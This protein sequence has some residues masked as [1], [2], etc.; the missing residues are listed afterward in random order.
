MPL[1]DV[2]RHFSGKLLLLLLAGAAA[3]VLVYRYGLSADGPR[4]TKVGTV[5]VETVATGLS[6]PW[7]LAFLP[8]GRMLVTE[9]TGTLRL[10][11]KDGKLSAPLSGVPEV[12][13]RGQ[14]GLLDVAIDPDFKSNNV[15]YLTYSEPGEGGVGTAVARGKL[16]ESG[17]ENVEVI[18]RQMP[19]V[20]GGN[21]F[22]SRLVFAPDGKLFVTL[23]ERFTF[24]PA[25][26][27]NNDLGK[28]VR[29]NPDG[30]V[31]KDNPFVGRQDA[32]PEI[33]SYGHRNPQGAAIHPETGRLWEVEF[34]PMGGD[35]LNIPQAGK[36]YGWPVVSWGSHYDGRQIPKP[37]THP[38][39]ADAIY[40]WN[41]VISPSGI[42]FYTGDAIP[43]W[44][45]NL[46]IGGLSSQAIVRLTLDGEKVVEEERIP[47]GTR[48]RDVVQGPD[49]AVYALTDEGNG[50]IL[51]LTLENS[52]K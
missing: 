42:T 14:G 8:D 49:G 45:G 18:F 4:N 43:A 20:E 30:S 21:H 46:L 15:V 16:G 48:I 27:L 44:K 17:L 52:P 51:R 10:V 39:F 1:R 9:R 41:P 5:K 26:D 38:E 7:G 28:I 24:A 11:S 31:P 37:P 40:H 23:G 29:I 34:G 19:K 3:V 13:V 50:E 32:R 12:V 33:W 22:G 35:E 2:A 6:H 47:M 36:N 25:Q